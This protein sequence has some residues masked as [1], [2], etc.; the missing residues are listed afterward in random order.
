MFVLDGLRQLKDG[1]L[2][3][4]SFHLGHLGFRPGLEV[5]SQ[6]SDIR[7]SHG[8]LNGHEL[9]LTPFQ[10]NRKDLFLFKCIFNEQPGVVARALSSFVKLGL[11]IVSL[12]SATID[13][14]FKAR[15]ILHF[16]LGLQQVPK[17][18]CPGRRHS[19]QIRRSAS[20]I[21]H[22]RSSI[23]SFDSEFFAHCFDAI[24]FEDIPG[25]RLSLPRIS[26]R[27][28]DDFYSPEKIKQLKIFREVPE[29]RHPLPEVGESL[30]RVMVQI[31]L[32]QA[33]HMLCFFPRQRR[34]LCT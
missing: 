31:E 21:T 13:K 6:Y 24:E 16:E 28:F 20:S 4:P 19:A 23:H 17:S 34:R 30:F 1:D 9:T 12:E 5:K 29:K 18:A 3:I 7:S 10:G 11:N 26:V 22:V 25:A 14:A 2:T 33:K 8:E 32:H 27:L 15:I